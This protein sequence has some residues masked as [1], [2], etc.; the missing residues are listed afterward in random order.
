VLSPA[1]WARLVNTRLRP[2]I[3]RTLTPTQQAQI[4]AIT[5]D[6]DRAA[7]TG[8]AGR[9]AGS[10]T[11]QNLSTA[12]VISRALQ[13]HGTNDPFLASLMRPLQWLYRIPEQQAQ[14]LLVDAMLDPA[15]AARL[16]GKASPQAVEAA[17]DA[18]RQR[19]SGIVLG[20]T[21]GTA[22]AVQ[23]PSAGLR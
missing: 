13:G 1:K 17:S 5:E 15:L 22:T 23:E 9:A 7:L 20:S 10:N 4:A 11:F 19:L 21:V 16:L 3:R 6:L 8:S 2:E 14:D 18:L 12:H